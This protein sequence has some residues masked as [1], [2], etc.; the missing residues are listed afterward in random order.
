MRRAGPG[1]IATVL[2][3]GRPA[4]AAD[5][6]VVVFFHG[7]GEP[8]QVPGEA[9]AKLYGL[10]GTELRIAMLLAEGMGIAGIAARLGSAA[11]TIRWHLKNLRAKTGSSR[12]S[13][14]TRLVMQAVSPVLAGRI[15]A[16]SVASMSGGGSTDF[17][18]LPRSDATSG[19]E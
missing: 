11:D 19:R 17:D 14:V 9:F 3:L 13:D 5:G 18:S 7:T 4:G 8:P 6:S 10:T 12:L 15:E 1:L 2:P 16:E